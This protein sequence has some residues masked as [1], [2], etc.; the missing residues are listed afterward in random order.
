MKRQWRQL[1][2][3]RTG[4]TETLDLGEE[5]AGMPSY[6]QEFDNGRSLYHPD[7]RRPAGRV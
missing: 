7:R 1:I 2:A 6:A 4:A 3:R 5:L